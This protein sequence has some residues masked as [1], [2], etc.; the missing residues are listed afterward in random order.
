MS[1]PPEIYSC[2]G[3]R[4]WMWSSG[5]YDALLMI[6]MYQSEIVTIAVI[7]AG[8]HIG[9]SFDEAGD[10]IAGR[11]GDVVSVVLNTTAYHLDMQCIKLC[12]QPL[13]VCG[14]IGLVPGY[15][16]CIALLYHNIH[17]GCNQIVQQT[18][19]AGA[20]EDVIIDLL[21]D[22]TYHAIDIR[23][24]NIGMDR[25][26]DIIMREMSIIIVLIDRMRVIGIRIIRI[27]SIRICVLLILE[28]QDCSED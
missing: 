2:L 19:G 7:I 12:K 15:M 17:H 24:N 3:C 9:G 6:V 11:I 21:A 16:D 25:L 13:D 26:I 10:Q 8:I 28:L 23:I 22:C 5:G 1:H 4:H 20:A 14:G 18:A 27:Q